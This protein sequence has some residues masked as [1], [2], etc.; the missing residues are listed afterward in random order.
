M[1]YE[2]G[3]MGFLRF[4][5]GGRLKKKVSKRRYGKIIGGILWVF[6]VVMKG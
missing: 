2:I 5:K 3:G 1:E 6:N 4:R